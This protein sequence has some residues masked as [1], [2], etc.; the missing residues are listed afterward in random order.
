MLYSSREWSRKSRNSQSE[1]LPDHPAAHDP[2]GNGT[3]I[4][5]LPGGRGEAGVPRA[6]AEAT[7]PRVKGVR[8]PKARDCLRSEE[9][10]NRFVGFRVVTAEKES[11]TF[12]R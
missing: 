8:E 7:S 9:R 1:T 12:V 6:T 2:A 10:E 11:G 4:H 3:P 5:R